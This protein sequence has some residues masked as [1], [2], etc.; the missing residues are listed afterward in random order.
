[1]SEWFDSQ[2][3]PSSFIL[4][5]FIR[6]KTR[7]HKISKRRASR[8]EF[9][10]NFFQIIFL[11]QANKLVEN[12][13]LKPKHFPHVQI[14]SSTCNSFSQ[15]MVKGLSM[16][17]GFS[18]KECAKALI[19]AENILSFSNSFVVR[20]IIDFFSRIPNWIALQFLKIQGSLLN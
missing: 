16:S 12:S 5:Q 15:S 11:F 4:F 6:N 8:L 18:P 10:L 19:S 20:K 9:N 1:M 2:K 14:F 3:K 7:P 17:I 13:L